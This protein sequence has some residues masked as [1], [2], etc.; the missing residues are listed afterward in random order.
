MWDT[1]IDCTEIPV[2][3]GQMCGCGCD[4][5]FEIFNKTQL[6]HISQNGETVEIT[7]YNGEHITDYV[8]RFRQFLMGIG[9]GEKTV[10]EYVPYADC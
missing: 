5:E 8:Q 6:T 9:F 10:D 2:N 3:C 1:H 7:F 4:E